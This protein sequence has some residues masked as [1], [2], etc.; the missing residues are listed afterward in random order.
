MIL[1][2]YCETPKVSVFLPIYGVEK[3]IEKCIRSLFVQT[4]DEMEFIFVDDCTPDKSCDILYK[5]VEE[6][7]QTIKEKRWSVILEH[8]KRNEGLAA[9]R[10]T[11]IELSKG[12][13]LIPCDSD[14]WVDPKM[15]EELYTKAISQN[16]DLIFCDY[17]VSENETNLGHEKIVKK[18]IND[19]SRNGLLKRLLLEETLN[20]VWSVMGKKEL[21][22]SI[23]CP[24]GGQAED[25]TFLIQLCALSDSSLYLDK[26]LYYYRHTPTSFFRSN[27]I[28]KVIR[29]YLQFHDNCE[30][31]MPLL[32]K[33]IEEGIP[34]LCVDVFLLKAKSV[35]APYLYNVQCR[36]FWREHY[37]ESSKYCLLN[38]YLTIKEKLK[39]I[40]FSCKV[41]YY[42]FLGEK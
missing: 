15:Y 23:E 6:Y 18:N 37:P 17:F 36:E 2:D 20:P 25:K 40:I 28:D 11:G 3:Y 42:S 30:L 29:R 16:A 10:K 34:S 13:Y 32:N 1:A 19:L 24:R 8:H 4:L 12:K 33:I 27:E 26:P 31:L 21:F 38:P 5:L 9:A 7:S 22:N 35:L 14:D 41:I 39:Y